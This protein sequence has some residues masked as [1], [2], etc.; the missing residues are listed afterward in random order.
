MAITLVR[1]NYFKNFSLLLCK[2]RSKNFR[3]L[4]VTS[5]LSRIYL[6]FYAKFVPAGLRGITA[7][8]HSEHTHTER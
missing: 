7:Y 5:D 8:S 2:L 4:T 3:L 1:L 6:R